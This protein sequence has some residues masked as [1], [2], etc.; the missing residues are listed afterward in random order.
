MRITATEQ[1][2]QKDGARSHWHMGSARRL[3]LQRQGRAG[4]RYAH[5]KEEMNVDAYLIKNMGVV[6]DHNSVCGVRERERARARERER[7]RDGGEGGQVPGVCCALNPFAPSHDPPQTQGHGR[8]MHGRTR[9]AHAYAIT[10]MA[11]TT[12]T[13]PPPPLC[14]PNSPSQS[15]TP[16]ALDHVDMAFPCHP[17]PPA[18]GEHHYFF[19]AVQ[20]QHAVGLRERAWC[21]YVAGGETS[22][23]PPPKHVWQLL[24]VSS[25][26]RSSVSSSRAQQSADVRC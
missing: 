10:A 14:G 9:G 3:L 19:R 1:K 21:S 16:A 17:V 2:E 25:S 18:G 23:L 7:E 5:Q 15:G 4:Q 6:S 12:Y 22:L 20:C 26:V 8:G 11:S 24:Q 13:P